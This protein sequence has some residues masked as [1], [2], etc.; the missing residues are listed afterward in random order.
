[1][2]QTIKHR[3]GSISSVRN[4]TSFGEAEI[5]IGSGSVDS[6]VVGPV[7]YIGKPG[8]TNAA[9]DYVPIS[10]MYVGSGLPSITPAQYGT[11]LDGLPYY[12]TTN[13]KIYILGANADG[14]SGH[15]EISI[16]SASIENFNSVVVSALPDGTVSGSSQISFLS[17]SGIPSG[18]VSSST[19]IESVIDDTYISASAAAS[20]FGSGG[21][22]GSTDI[23]ALN[24]FTGSIQ[25]EVD[26][27]T[28]ATSSYLTSV[29]SGTVSG[30]SQVVD[31][32]PSGVISGSSQ[33][34]I[35]ESQISDLDH[36][37]ISDLPSG[38]VSSSAQITITESQISDLTHYT[39]SDVKTKLNTENVISSSAQIVSSLPGG[40]VSG[41]AQI[42]SNLEG[43]SLSVATLIAETYI[44]SSSV[45]HMTTSFS[46]GSTIFGD[47]INDTHQFTGSMFVSGSIFFDEID[48]GNF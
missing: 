18:I 17:I 7:V 30:S 26:T 5:V 24:T 2:A 42:I 12:D 11:T 4:I 9:N 35:T 41:S 43:Q 37:T 14:T 32:L 29:P 31:L 27:L 20:G 8:G 3:R 16:T 47:D 34:T 28:A 46:S 1:M 21:G 19:Q 48:G 40:L 39:D 15:T 44:V 10:K 13:K 6:K 33:I 38:T 22:G 36:F 45:T 25:T 23:S